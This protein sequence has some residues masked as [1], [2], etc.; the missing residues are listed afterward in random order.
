M[1]IVV[2]SNEY[3][4]LKFGVENEAIRG[5]EINAA[6]DGIEVRV[7]V[8]ASCADYRLFATAVR[9]IMTITNAKAYDEDEEEIINVEEHF[10]E[11]WIDKCRETD[12]KFI[13]TLARRHRK[14]ATLDGLIAPICIG[15]KILNNFGTLEYSDFPEYEYSDLQ[16]YLCSVQWYLLDMKGTSTNLHITEEDEER[17]LSISAINIV[18]NKV[19]EFDYI[20]A[21]DL[22]AVFDHDNEKHV[23]IPFKDMWKTLPKD[24]F[25]VIDEW[26]YKREG[27]LTPEA[28]RQ[29]MTRSAPFAISSFSQKHVLP[30]DGFDERQNTVILMWNPDISSFKL[31]QHKDCLAHLPALTLNWSVWEHEK[32]KNG[33]RFFLVR[34]GE[35]NTGIVMSGVFTSGPYEEKDWSGRGRQ[36]FYMDM[37]VNVMIDPDTTDMITTDTLQQRIPSFKWDGGHSGRLMNAEQ[38][39]ELENVWAEYLDKHKGDFDGKKMSRIYALD[40]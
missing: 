8:F 13:S 11:E 1:N 7:C 40:L 30:G 25:R 3:P 9:A 17:S 39:Q 12:L 35:G 29:M 4:C 24:T 14:T 38:A 34:C 23:L 15:P 37:D 19:A 20:S 31:D 21:A 18:G 27:K 33:D 36:I 6:D 2:T 16:D 26:Q 32:A 22:F 5:I 10:N 28:V